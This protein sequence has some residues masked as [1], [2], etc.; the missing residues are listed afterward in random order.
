MQ[1]RLAEVDAAF[2]D[3]ERAV[4]RRYLEG[5]TEALRSQCC[6][7]WPQHREATSSMVARPPR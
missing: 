6:S 3:D 2:D 5:V 1:A 4:V 7:D